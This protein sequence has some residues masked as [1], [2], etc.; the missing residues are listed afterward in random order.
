MI[1]EKIYSFGEF[2]QVLKCLGDFVNFDR[3]VSYLVLITQ[4]FFG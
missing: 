2:G 3:Q 1:S 4:T